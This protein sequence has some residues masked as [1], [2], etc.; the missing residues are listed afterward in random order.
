MKIK[1]VTEDIEKIDEFVSQD[2]PITDE[3][4]KKILSA[5]DGQFSKPMTSQELFASIGFPKE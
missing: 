2:P 4:V 1:E 3:D 5:A